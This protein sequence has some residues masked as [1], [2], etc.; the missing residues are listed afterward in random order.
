MSVSPTNENSASYELAG[1][2]FKRRGGFGKHMPNSWQLRYFTVKDGFLS[3]Y[4]TSD[5]TLPYRGRID[6]SLEFD[7][8]SGG[9]L[10]GSP[11]NYTMQIS[12][13]NPN[14]EKWK[15][16]A[17]TMQDHNN[18]Q[19]VI[20]SYQVSKGGP[21]RG[22]PS[23]TDNAPRNSITPTILEQRNSIHRSSI[24]PVSNVAPSSP[25]TAPARRLSDVAP[26][27]NTQTNPNTTANLPL[28]PVPIKI[29]SSNPKRAL[30]LKEGSAISPE[31]SELRIHIIY[32][33]YL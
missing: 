18:W 15:L 24:S 7:V 13:H 5:T 28:N 17:E 30:K 22:R 20:Q 27:S 31:Q 29:V 23:T 21:A 32:Y 3:Y 26:V 9:P 14:E 25:A 4:D 10:E 16:C 33:N 1:Y 12:P 6:L 19:L 2:L 11:T 8:S